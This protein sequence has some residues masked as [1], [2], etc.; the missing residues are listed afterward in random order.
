MT[1]IGYSVRT[2][3]WRYTSWYNYEKDLFEFHELYAV[4]TPGPT[5]NFAGI[6]EYREIQERL[7]QMDADYQAGQ[8]SKD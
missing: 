8:Y 2:G 4:D 5:V 7:H 1:H 3:S 6:P